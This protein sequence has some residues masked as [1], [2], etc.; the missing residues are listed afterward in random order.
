MKLIL[1]ISLLLSSLLISCGSNE[2]SGTT[3]VEN[4]VVFS[5]VNLKTT[6]NSELSIKLIP[7]EHHPKDDPLA[8][9]Y[10]TQTDSLGNFSFSKLSSGL[11]SIEIISQVD[12]LGIL[13]QDL[14][15]TQDTLVIPNITLETLSSIAVYLP[16]SLNIEPLEIEIFGSS[17]N[18]L[19]DS[20]TH[21]ENSFTKYSFIQVP[22][23]NTIDS[24]SIYNANEKTF[25]WYNQT[26]LSSQE[27]SLSISDTPVESL[28]PTR[29]FSTIVGVSDSMV[30]YHNGLEALSASIRKQFSE[31]QDVFKDDQLNE[32]IE[33]TI[34]SIYTYSG[35]LDN[36]KTPPSSEFT[37]KVLYSPFE[38]YGASNWDSE[39]SIIAIVTPANISGGALGPNSYKNVRQSLALSRGAYLNTIEEV[40]IPNNL[41]SNQEFVQ[42]GSII[43]YRSNELSWSPY[44]LALINQNLST[45]TSKMDSL[46]LSSFSKLKLKFTNNTNVN[47]DLAIIELYGVVP[48]SIGVQNTALLSLTTNSAGEITIGSNPFLST[49]KNEL[50][51]SNFLVKCSYQG[52]DYF[53]WLPYSKLIEAYWVDQSSDKIEFSHTFEIQTL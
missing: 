25:T 40:I 26:V 41:I 50:L 52:Q 42:T 27:L 20:K 49:D 46:I 35:S 18:K 43:N 47:L 30:N 53:Q 29:Q 1:S 21:L 8:N 13:L 48:Q 9:I 16:D 11:Y 5:K 32:V 45:S 51:F 3:V 10:T 31:S 28:R 6:Q 17:L 39:N 22:A 36:E 7:K 14:E 19:Q 12:S 38:A 4:G 44:N 15:V 2:S 24:I 23:S 37:Y 34:D 33:F